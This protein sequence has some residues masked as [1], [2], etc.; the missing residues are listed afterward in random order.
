[1]SVNEAQESITSS[2]FVKWIWFLNW[3]AT[4]DF[5]RQDFYL[6]QIAMEICRGQVKNPKKLKLQDFILNFQPKKNK[7]SEEQMMRSKRFWLG[8]SGVIG[9]KKNLKKRKVPKAKE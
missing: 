2:E 1:M 7:F 9:N 3:H 6:A 8:A 5:N 4:E